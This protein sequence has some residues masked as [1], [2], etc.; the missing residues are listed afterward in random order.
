[1]E[2]DVADGVQTFPAEPFFIR[3]PQLQYPD[4]RIERAQNS[5]WSVGLGRGGRTFR[6]SLRGRK[7]HDFRARRSGGGWLLPD[8]GAVLGRAYQSFDD[9]AALD[10]MERAIAARGKRLQD[11]R[12]GVRG[13]DLVFADEAEEIGVE[14]ADYGRVGELLRAFQR[15][16]LSQSF[17]RTRQTPSFL[18]P[19]FRCRAHPGRRAL[20]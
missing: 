20:R 8:A 3:A 11:A 14:A 4:R 13:V 16:Y 5:G 12:D 9:T 10:R 2:E 18:P 1:M 15:E 17:K 7:L 6:R 19:G